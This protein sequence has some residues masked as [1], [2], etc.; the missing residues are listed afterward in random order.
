MNRLIS[1]DD[2]ENIVVIISRIVQ[3]KNLEKLKHILDNID[4]EHYLI[5]F[6]PNVDYL[7]NIK[8]LLP[9]STIITNATEQEKN[10]VLKKSKIFLNTSEEE[11]FGLVFT[12]TMSYGLIPIAH[13]SG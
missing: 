3:D 8:R 5:G 11:S 9:K 2:K 7:N 1:Y 13:N 4:C 10:E 6:A 12:E